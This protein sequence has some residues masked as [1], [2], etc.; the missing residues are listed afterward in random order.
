[1]D[2]FILTH[3]NSNTIYAI[4]TECIIEDII[5]SI[6]IVNYSVE[7]VSQTLFNAISSTDTCV[8]IDEITHDMIENENITEIIIASQLQQKYTHEEYKFEM[9][10]N[11]KQSLDQFVDVD[12]LLSNYISEIINEDYYIK[13]INSSIELPELSKHE[14]AGGFACNVT[15]I[16]NDNKFDFDVNIGIVT[17]NDAVDQYYEINKNETEYSVKMLSD[18]DDN[19]DYTNEDYNSDDIGVIV[20]NIT[21]IKE[22]NKY[23][24]THDC[25]TYM[26]GTLTSK[27]DVSYDSMSK[28]QKCDYIMDLIYEIE[29]KV[30]EFCCNTSV[31]YYY[32]F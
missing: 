29:C 21:P 3:K 1:M 9:I 26:R 8:N 17:Y 14:D 7:R 24:G 2:Q 30:H 10:K 27:T 16:I 20:E 5:K 18:I 4:T 25:D 12:L 22:T 31:G 19:E 32:R 6:G 28:E 23:Y 11:I 13:V 15:I